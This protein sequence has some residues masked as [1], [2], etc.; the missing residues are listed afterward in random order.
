MIYKCKMCGGNLDIT[1]GATT[2]ECEY[3]GTNQ[4]VP[5]IDNEKKLNL[6]N[7][8]NRLRMASEFDKAAGVYESIVSEFPEEAEGYWGLCLCKFG[9]EYVDDPA[10]GKKIPTCHRTMFE[11]IFDDNDFDMA[12]EY[13]DAYSKRL[14]RDEAKEIDRLQRAV[15]DIVNTE[16]PYD[17][18]ICYK[19]TDENGQRTKDSVL[20]QDMYDALTAKGY[21]VFFARIS[22]E[23]RIGKEY[24]PYIFAA[25]TSAKVML[26]VGTNYEYYNAVW[27]KNE[28][29]RYLALMKNDRNK[30]LIPCYADIDAYDMP[31]EFK[32]LQAQDMNKIGFMQDLVRGIGKLIPLVDEKADENV[33]PVQQVQTIVRSTNADNLIKRG[34]MA[35]ADGEFD[36]AKEYFDKVLD[37]DAECAQAYWGMFLAGQ[38]CNETDIA[39]KM[40]DN[41][42]LF[43]DKNLVKAVQFADDSF[44]SYMK[45]F[46]DG[47]VGIAEKSFDEEKEKAY[48]QAVEYVNNGFTD[49]SVIDLIKQLEGYKDSAALL[50]KAEEQK[51]IA[52]EKAAEEKR[53]A[54][55]KAA[56]EKEIRELTEKRDSLNRAISNNKK[57]VADL[58]KAHQDL[59]YLTEQKSTTETQLEESEKRLNTLNTEL[60]G[61]GLFAGKRKK[62]INE[63]LARINS[64]R[65]KLRQEL[66]EIEVNIGKAQGYINRAKSL[67]SDE[68]QRMENELAQTE[69]RLKELNG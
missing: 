67:P 22:L 2:C 58:N 19:E 14:Y 8:A 31:Q 65:S 9:I 5:L 54:A 33:Q 52:A 59:D 44:L 20:A 32:H 34:N 24:E 62:E 36:S 66:G 51:R 63:E 47:A 53:I 39:V 6:F 38:K 56:R 26:A 29:S 1:D 50:E 46:F 41:T 43:A 13:A 27:V 55:E 28:W 7:R 25:L 61:L 18:F 40:H 60:S 15:L 48:Q 35:I 69:S 12:C 49:T 37:E 3:C 11:S 16:E 42:D 4:T 64:E 57:T 10:T 17:I 21:K 23:D 45:Q 30:T 68:V